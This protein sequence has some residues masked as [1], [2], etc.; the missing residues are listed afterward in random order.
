MATTQQNTKD[1]QQWAQQRKEIARQQLARIPGL[2]KALFAQED[3]TDFLS[4]LARFPSYNYLNLLIIHDKCPEATA[5]AVFTVWQDLLGSEDKSQKVLKPDAIRNGIDLLAPFTNRIG[6]DDFELIWYS[7]LVFDI[8]HTNIRRFKPREPVYRHD[9][10]H[11]L[12]LCD[13]AAVALGTYY[14][15]RVIYEADTAALRGSGALGRIGNHTVSVLRTAKQADTLFWLTEALCELALGEVRLQRQSRDVLRQ[16]MHVC[17]YKLWGLS[18]PGILP[19]CHSVVPEQ[20]Q[21]M[22]LDLLQ[23]N[24]FRLHQEVADCYLSQREDEDLLQS[25]LASLEEI[26]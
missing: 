5:L 4:L 7:A 20:E 11:E 22:F 10:M 24:V 14:Q 3:L 21:E 23:R 19:G 8:R 12:M 6:E 25:D 17:L 2:T 16:C 9:S 18:H 1:G 15:H 13:A 26:S